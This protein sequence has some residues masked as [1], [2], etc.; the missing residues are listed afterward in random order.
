MNGVENLLVTVNDVEKDRELAP[1]PD[2]EGSDPYAGV[3]WCSVY[4]APSLAYISCT[5][6]SAW[7]FKPE[8]EA[9]PYV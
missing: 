9:T 8:I 5:D 3:E 7:G 6:V 2:Q 1:K 4:R